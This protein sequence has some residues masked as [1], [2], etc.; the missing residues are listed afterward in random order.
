ML[1]P[2]CHRSPLLTNV[3]RCDII[4]IPVGGIRRKP[5]TGSEIHMAEQR[6]PHCSGKKT[7]RS[8]AERRQLMNRL[9]RIE[10]QVRGLQ[11]M[12]EEDAYCADILT[13]SAAVSAALNAFNRDLLARHLHSCVVRDIRSGDDGAVDELTALLSKLMK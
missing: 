12:L 5:D 3:R 11:R 10:G 7:E 13:Q 6:C 1:L 2:Y 9:K 8:E 4:K